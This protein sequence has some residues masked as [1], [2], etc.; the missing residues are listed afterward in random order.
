MYESLEEESSQ[1]ALLS[2]T[3]LLSQARSGDADAQFLLGEAFRTGGGIPE[4]HEHA[5]HWYLQAAE[6]GHPAAQNNAGSM[7]L[8]GMGAPA[9]AAEAVEWYRKAALQDFPEAHF[10]LG[11]RYLHGSGVEMD[12][13]M[14][15]A[16]LFKASE[17]G[18]V[19]ALGEL[20]TLFRFGRGVEQNYVAAAELHVL[21]AL[22]GDATSVGNLHDYWPEVEKAA[23]EGSAS[24]AWS[25]AKMYDHGIVVPK[26]K[27]KVFAW[28]R[29][30]QQY[31][32]RDNGDETMAE[33]AEWLNSESM[34]LPDQAKQE[35]EV[36]LAQMRQSRM[37]GDQ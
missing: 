29:W 33:L 16:C 4:N 14:A 28:L 15:A 3:K 12:V 24:A 17:H 26:D 37:E 35:A 2:V 36:L 25:L 11:L 32:T 9:N 1:P 20:G 10:N 21:A 18:H 34:L 23:L 13:E 27:A 31:G 22:E 8:N 6:Q 7:L 5:L 30:T 19:E